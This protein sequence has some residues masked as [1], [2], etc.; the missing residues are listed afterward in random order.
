MHAGGTTILC[1]GFDPDQTF[2]LV[3]NSGIT[4][5]VAVPTMFQMLQ[6]H[7]RWDEAEQN[8]QAESYENAIKK[9]DL[10][11]PQPS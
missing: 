10:F 8:Y 7:P 2:D 3:E 6:E 5:Y 1:N 9:Y 11:Q 4:H